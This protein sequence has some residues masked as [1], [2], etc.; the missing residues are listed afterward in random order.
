MSEGLGRA[1]G[2]PVAFKFAGETRLFAR[3]SITDIGA[4]EEHLKT[5]MPDPLELAVKAASGLPESI[6][7]D[8]V[9]RAYDDAKKGKQIGDEEISDFVGTI[10]GIC[11]CAFLSLNKAN[12]G[13]YSLEEVEALAGNCTEEELANLKKIIER[14]MDEDPE[15]NSTGETISSTNS[16]APENVENPGTPGGDG[17]ASCVKGADSHKGTL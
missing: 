16:T 6:A 1:A 14:T 9:R 2:S 3:L 10:K 17:F 4:I 13:R 11:F 15:G 8:L 5:I 7:K 12:P